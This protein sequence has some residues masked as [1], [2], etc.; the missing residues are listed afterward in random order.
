M[1]N[2]NS[3]VSHVKNYRPAYLVLCGPGGDR[4]E[5]MMFASCLQ[6]SKGISIYANITKQKLYDY[7]V[8]I[9]DGQTKEE[10]ANNQETKRSIEDSNMF[11]VKSNIKT[12]CNF[13][14]VWLGDNSCIDIVHFNLYI[15]DI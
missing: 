7:N 2:L 13:F 3:V 15:V 4:P 9:E 11:M 6:K 12:Y 5:L 8:L 10:E 1:L 14:M